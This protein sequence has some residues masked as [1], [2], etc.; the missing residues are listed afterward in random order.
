MPDTLL[1][2]SLQPFV[3]IVT[4]VY[5]GED[6]LD[7]CI[8]SVLAQTY[9][10]WEYIIVNNCSSDRS[11]EIA[12]TYA[13]KDDRIRVVDCS[14]FV[15]AR[16]NFNRAVTLISPESSYC[17]LVLADDW[18]FAECLSKMVK[19]AETNPS[20][21]I[22]GAYRLD[23]IYVNCDGLPYHSPIVPGREL[24]RWHLLSGEFVFG[25]PTSLLF[26]SEIV[27]QR[28]PFYGESSL[29]A[30]TEACYEI[31]RDWNFGFVHQ[32]L[33]FSRR[34]NESI[35]SSSKSFNPHLLDRLI[36]LKKYGTEYLTREEMQR[37]SK[38]VENAYYRYLANSLLD[39][40]EQSFWDHHREGWRNIP[41]QIQRVKLAKYVAAELLNKV[42][43][44]KATLERIFEQFRRNK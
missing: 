10:R 20:V 17:K 9:E 13:A 8:E 40:R 26:R 18:L 15:E 5:N 44:P 1:D 2:S 41:M 3:S 33:T 7:Q 22:V 23:D 28:K 29:H 11:L 37:I 30:D 34:Q 6:Y 12:R 4:P 38:L 25:S 21:G 24:C 19:L 39:F 36:M 32:V 16:K 43:N 31:L 27:R 14:E 35:S 42:G